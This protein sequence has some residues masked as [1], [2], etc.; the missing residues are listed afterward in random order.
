M[1]NE[2][3]MVRIETSA[4]V[5]GV[6]VQLNECL[7][8]EKLLKDQMEIKERNKKEFMTLKN[9]IRLC[10]WLVILLPKG[11]FAQQHFSYN[12]YMHNMGPINP[13]WYLSD[14][15]YSFH[16]GVRKQ[17]VGIEGAPSTL[18]LNGHIPFNTINSATGLNLMY[19]TFG[20]EKLLNVS[21]FFA[22]AVRLSESE[23][24]LSASISVGF[25]RY[26]ALYSALDSQ[27]PIFRDDVQETSF[28]LG[29]GLMF[30]IPEKFFAGFSVPHLSMREMGIASNDAEY[31]FN[32][33][34]YLMLGYLGSLNE[35]FKLKPVILATH[36]EG[37]GTAVD[38]STTLVI[39]DALGLGLNYGS[40]RDLGAQVSVYANERLRIG[41]SYQFGTNS[42]GLS[43][44][45]NNT[46][47]IGV[48][49]RFG[50]G[51]GKKLL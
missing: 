47:E 23:E 51:I 9:L 35:V 29:I 21:S 38:F 1:E 40:S 15:A 22:K 39:Q 46:H 36:T 37:L 44:G 7:R 13:T 16:A 24:Y 4:L 42:Y 31:Q 10:V 18:I 34:Y 27:D 19:D 6:I 14:R 41:Y 43:N 17:W 30:Y 28:T 50:K 2:K 25:N 8:Q 33:P 49:Y 48:G 45:G 12:Q 32:T 5:R 20:P 26:E 3:G 11:G